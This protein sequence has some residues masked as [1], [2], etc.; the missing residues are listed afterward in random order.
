M[1][2][3]KKVLKIYRMVRCQVLVIGGDIDQSASGV[4]IEHFVL[5]ARYSFALNP[6]FLFR[7]FKN[8]SS[9]NFLCYFEEHPIIN[10]LTK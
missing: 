5:L 4:Q 10:L 3:Y 7:L 6:D 2:H 9:D 1:S 8:I